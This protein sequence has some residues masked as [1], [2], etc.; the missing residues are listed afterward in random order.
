MW[1]KSL[2]LR[3]LT[4]GFFPSGFPNRIAQALVSL[5]RKRRPPP[6]P[7]PGHQQRDLR[8]GLHQVAHRLP[9][10]QQ[11]PPTIIS[12]SAQALGTATP[13]FDDVTGVPGITRLSQ[14][15][16]ASS[17]GPFPIASLPPL[18]NVPLSQCMMGVVVRYSVLASCFF[19]LSGGDTNFS[20]SSETPIYL[21][22]PL[23]CCRHIATGERHREG[24][25]LC[26]A[27]RGGGPLLMRVTSG[28][29]GPWG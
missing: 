27:L 4:Q 6:Q 19:P 24:A 23:I 12:Q 15:N 7:R 14:V 16:A 11:P 2:Q 20:S 1:D 9:Q 13:P 10:P 26:S 29:N 18:S 25:L 21:R 5:S 17:S 8:P 22:K 3:S 28:S